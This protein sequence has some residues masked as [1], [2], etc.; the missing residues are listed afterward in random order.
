MV[1]SLRKVYFSHPTGHYTWEKKSGFKIQ[2][3]SPGVTGAARRGHMGHVP[4]PSLGLKCPLQF[5]I[6]EL[7]LTL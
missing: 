3:S 7:F 2:A 4:L 5:F 1:N 6:N